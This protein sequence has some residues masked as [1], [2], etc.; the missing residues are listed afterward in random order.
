MKVDRYICDACERGNLRREDIYEAYTL[1]RF[2]DVCF[3]IIPGDCV[4][5]L[6]R[7]CLARLFRNLAEQA[8]AGEE[9]LPVRW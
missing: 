6:C 4:R 3:S 8:E 2:R 7:A 5:H 9:L 1:V